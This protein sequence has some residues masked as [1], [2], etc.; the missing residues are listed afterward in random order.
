[1]NPRAVAAEILSH[2]LHD[3]LS[4]TAA[5]TQGF[6][7]EQPADQ[8]LIQEFCYGVMRWQPQ[9]EIWLDS[10]LTKAF[11]PKDTDIRALLLIGLYQLEYMRVPDHAAVSETVAAVHELKKPWA[12]NLVNAVLR[13]FLRQQ[14][15][16]KEKLKDSQMIQFAHP[17][18]LIH[19]IKA[20]WPQHWQSIL[21]ANN[22]R[23]P[24]SLRVNLRQQDRQSYLTA[25]AQAGIEAKACQHASAGILLQSSCR[26]EQLPG[27]AEGAVSVQDE[28]AQLAA[29]LLAA[30]DGD[31]VLDVCAAPGGK[32]CHILERQAELQQLLAI[33]IDPQRLARIQDNLDRL[34][35]RAQLICADAG[36]TDQWWDGKLFDRILLDAPCSATGVIRRHPDIKYLRKATDIE[37]LAHLQQ[38]IL[39]GIWPLL[40]PG[41]MLLYATC[42]VLPQEN[43]QQIENFLRH[44]TDAI[45]RPITQSWGIDV[46]VGRQILSGSDNMDGFYYA[47]LEKAQQAR[48]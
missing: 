32:T 24:M 48:Q 1:M 5:L 10:L 25:L 34:H 27:F 4:L 30:K 7:R 42:S 44:H 31:R 16:L 39:Q 35:L 28:A 21:H 36:A 8:G 13:N 22:V 14:D 12:K 11:K 37:Q 20:A 18:W 17:I 19:M 43:S 45:Y 41:G 2:V 29:E 33:D 26:V 46:G 40:K 9:L 15:E 38:H 23:P 3:G 6:A 47:Q